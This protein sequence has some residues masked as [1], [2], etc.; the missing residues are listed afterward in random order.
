MNEVMNRREA[1][2][3]LR[4]RYGIQAKP[5]TLAKY[6]SLGGG[7]RFRRAGRFPVYSAADLDAWAEGRLTGLVASTAE[8]EPV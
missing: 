2:E 7:P 5:A 1:S 8:L 4:R 3:Y 6:A